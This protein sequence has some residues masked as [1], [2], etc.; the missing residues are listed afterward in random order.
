MERLRQHVGT[1]AIFAEGE[2]IRTTI[3]LGAA[4]GFETANIAPGALVRV[5]DQALYRAKNNGRNRSEISLL[6]AKDGEPAS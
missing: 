2:E 3:S 5:A 6:P 1:K 4:V